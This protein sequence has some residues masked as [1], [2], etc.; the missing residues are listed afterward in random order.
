MDLADIAT[1]QQLCYLIAHERRRP[2][3][4]EAWPLPPPL[5]GHWI[6][7]QLA[8]YI[9]YPADAPP[10][11]QDHAVLH[12]L[13]HVLLAIRGARSPDLD[14]PEAADSPPALTPATMLAALMRSCYDDEHECAAELFATLLEQRWRAVRGDGLGLPLHAYTRHDIRWLAQ[15]AGALR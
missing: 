12:E 9:F 3:C 11:L 5:A 14:D 13:G 4:L 6:A 2:I 10:P 15:Q 7:T 8:D 1:V